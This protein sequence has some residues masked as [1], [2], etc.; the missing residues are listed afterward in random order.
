MKPRK[1]SRYIPPA[2]RIAHWR[3]SGCRNMFSEH[4]CTKLLEDG[5]TLFLCPS[6]RIA[7]GARFL[8]ELP[9]KNRKEVL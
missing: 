2:H 8:V 6:C 1:H 3:C 7:L 5:I 9:S 4:Q